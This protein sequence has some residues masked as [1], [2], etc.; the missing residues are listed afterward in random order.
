[1]PAA[2]SRPATRPI[3]LRRALP[4]ALVSA[5]ALAV[6]AAMMASASSAQALDVSITIAPPPLPVYEQPP[7]PDVDYLWVPGYWAWSPAGY[8]WVP[9]TWVLPPEPGL[10]WTPGYWAWRDGYYRWHAGYWGPTV[11]FYGGINYGFG[12]SG[13]GYFGGHWDHDHFFYN[14]SVNNFG[15]VHITNVYNEPVRNV[16]VNRISFNGGHGGINARPSAAEEAAARDHHLDP[17]SVQT[18]HAHAASENHALFA[19]VNHGAPPIAA[20][21]HPGNFSGAGVVHA[22]GAGAAPART[23]AA[24]QP[25]TAPAGIRPQPHAAGPAGN[26]ASQHAAPV[27]PAAVPHAMTV[28]PHSQGG[29]H[30]QR[31]PRPAPVHPAAAPHPAAPRQAPA[32]RPAP[33]PHPA[34]QGGDQGGD[35]GSDHGGD[36]PH[37]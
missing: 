25:A 35:H 8:Y 37:P 27:H 34:P 12:Y 15:G 22:R 18:A 1:M 4:L 19:S 17:T 10:L 36:R 13:I 31:A 14:R 20:T 3:H 29:P 21:S 16:S 5:L 7:I 30:P 28:Q 2:A 9:G 33:Q 24:V 11:G 26:R 23:N 32:A 6:P